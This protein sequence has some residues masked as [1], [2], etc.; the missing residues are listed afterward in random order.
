MKRACATSIAHKAL[1][2]LMS[3]WLS[4]VVLLLVCNARMPNPAMDHCPLM[5]LGA[6]CDKADKNKPTESLTSETNQHEIDCCAFIPAFFDKSRVFDGEQQGVVSAP[7][8][9]VI[10][11]PSYS[12]VGHVFKPASSFQSTA[13][14]KNDTFLKNHTFRI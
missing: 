12:P 3:F 7:V 14:L 2:G 13:L 8:S 1:V 10:I 9:S 11:R 5:K 4:G 6:R